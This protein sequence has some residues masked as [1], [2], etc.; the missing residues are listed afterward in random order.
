MEDADG[1]T[2]ARAGYVTA[3]WGGSTRWLFVGYGGHSAST[4]AQVLAYDYETGGWHTIFLAE[5]DD[6]GDDVDISYV[7]ASLESDGTARLHAV[8]EGAAACRSFMFE[9][10]DRAS[11]STAARK[12][13]DVGYLNWSEDD[14]ADP[15]KSSG[16]MRILMDAYDLSGSTSGEHIDIQYGIDGATWTTATLSGDFL[17]SVKSL[18]FGTGGAG[19]AAKTIRIRMNLKRGS[20]NTN[21]PKVVD[22]ELQVRTK[23][24]RLQGFVCNIDVARSAALQ[25]VPAKTVIE[26]INTTI[27]QVPAVAFE[28]ADTGTLYVDVHRELQGDTTSKTGVSSPAENRRTS[29]IIPLSIEQ[30]LPA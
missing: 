22:W 15:H 14:L 19:I 17:S 6:I 30:V 21:S 4:Y 9:N 16:V 10:Y 23:Q 28:W 8:S 29:G 3:M 13:K 5:D 18:S 1:P 26:R 20:T 12:Y 11:T 24:E 25:R 2:T 7:F 27:D